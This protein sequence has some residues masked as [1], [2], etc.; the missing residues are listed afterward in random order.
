MNQMTPCMGPQDENSDIQKRNN[1]K[2]ANSKIFVFKNELESTIYRSLNNIYH[3]EYT[4][5]IHTTFIK[6]FLENLAKKSWEN[7]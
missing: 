3:Q 6:H 5:W 1:T 7:L 2:F 4:F